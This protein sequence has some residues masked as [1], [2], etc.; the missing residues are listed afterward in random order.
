[1]ND[2]GIDQRY[3]PFR[4]PTPNGIAERFMRTLMGE[5]VWHHRFET[6]E[7]TEEVIAEWIKRYNEQRL[8]SSLDDKS[9]ASFREILHEEICSA[10]VEIYGVTTPQA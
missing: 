2:L 5:M 8:H 1:M 3:T 6:M 4:C 10:S 9:T 7:E